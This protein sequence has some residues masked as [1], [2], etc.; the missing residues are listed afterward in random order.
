MIKSSKNVAIII[1][2]FGTFPKN[3]VTFLDSCKTN[4]YIDWIIITDEIVKVEDIPV[5]VHIIHET[6]GSV[7]KK[8]KKA[9]GWND[10]V[11]DTSYKLCDYRPV[12]GVAFSDYISG[13]NYWGY[14]DID[15]V[16]GDLWKFIKRGVVNGYDK[17][18][19]LGHLTLFKNTEEIN[20]RYRLPTIYNGKKRYLY[21][22]AFSTSKACHFDEDWGIN[23]IYNQYGFLTYE[24]SNIVN[25]PFPENMDLRSIDNRYLRLPQVYVYSKGHCKFFYR[26]AETISVEEFGY[27]HFQKRLFTDYLYKPHDVFYVNSSGYHALDSIN[28]EVVSSIINKKSSLMSRIK[29]MKRTYMNTNW[30]TDRKLFNHYFP[31]K[32]IYNRIFKEKNFFI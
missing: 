27:F 1:P 15:V 11:L 16:Y 9:V 5:N 31:I 32:H 29:Y 26:E 10:I 12:Y 17:I 24:N 6:F 25:E 3:F 20:N 4:R 22:E 13:Y 7:Q 23:I 21:R 30:F 19:H 14:S 18:G 28:K 8:I 2:Y